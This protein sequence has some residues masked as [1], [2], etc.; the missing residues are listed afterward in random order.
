YIELMCG[1]Y[2]DN[3]PDFTWLMPEE[4]KDFVQYFMPYRDVGVVKNATKDA[5]VNIEKKDDSLLV[6]AYTTGIYPNCTVIVQQ[7]NKTLLKE[8]YM[9]SPANSFEQTVP[10]END[11][12]Q[13]IKILVTDEK[14]NIL[15][16]WKWEAPTGNNI[17]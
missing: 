9:A 12:M 11:T 3:Q 13:G 2:T 16:D 4:E 17:P 14:Y 15:V 7:G 8:S 1:V 10:F 6:K 5:M